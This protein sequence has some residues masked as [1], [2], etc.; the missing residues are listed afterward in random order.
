M[1]DGWQSG[2]VLHAALQARVWRSES[3]LGDGRGYWFG[4]KICG[5]R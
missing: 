2:P 4:V 5:A 1:M 3:G